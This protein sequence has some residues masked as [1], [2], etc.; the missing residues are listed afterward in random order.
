MSYLKEK[1]ARLSKAVIEKLADF[2]FGAPTDSK[3]LDMRTD[4]D[5]PQMFQAL[6]F[7]RLVGEAYDAKAGDQIADIL[8]RLSLSKGRGSRKEGVLTM[9]SGSYPSPQAIVEGFEKIKRQ[10]EEGSI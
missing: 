6:F 8:E 2:L 1:I 10:V 4:I 5:T 3:F 9:T 7:Y